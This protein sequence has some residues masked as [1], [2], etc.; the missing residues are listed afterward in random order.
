MALFELLL[1]FEPIHA[2][3][4]VPS[5][6]GPNP[7]WEYKLA[8]LRERP[9]PLAP[10]DCFFVGSSMVDNGLDPAAFATAYAGKSGARLTCFN[11]G[12]AGLTASGTAVV[13]DYLTT[14]Y[15]PRLI[16]YGTALRDF[17]AAESAMNA[18][19]M[20]SAWLRYERGE[21]SP[22]GWL[23]A[24]SQ[25]YGQLLTWRNWTNIDF[26]D[27]RHN[28]TLQMLAPYGY[29]N[30]YLGHA[31][32]IDLARP[33]VQDTEAGFDLFRRVAELEPGEVEAL[34]TLASLKQHGVKLVVVDMPLHPTYFGY[35][36]GGETEYDN[37]MSA[38]Y[39]A[40]AAAGLPL[41]KRH[42]QPEIP[43]AGWFDRNHLNGRGATTLSTWLGT[44][45]GQQKP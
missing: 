6:G 20:D 24:H 4:P 26:G 3:L 19:R 10:V 16:V 43:T 8:S 31:L 21:F 28:M 27:F 32:A 34:K 17:L 33:P 29:T 14:H 38:V 11:L 37:R 44:Q 18:A 22:N 9:S 39:R 25:A 42:G 45:I 13:A 5:T 41:I 40:V 15:R 12:A 35:L 23:V 36:P 30:A 1:R 2:R 7:R